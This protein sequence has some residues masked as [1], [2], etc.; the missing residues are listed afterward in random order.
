MAKYY[1]VL[2]HW[3]NGE[4]TKGR[5]IG[6]NAA[7]LCSCEGE[8]VLLGPHEDLYPIPPC[9]K[10]GASFKIIRGKRPNYVDHVEEV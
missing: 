3:K 4:K 1:D 2:V 5:G 7:W 6:N 9:P 8:E 10:C